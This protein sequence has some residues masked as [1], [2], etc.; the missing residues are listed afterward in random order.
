MK[1]PVSFMYN[2]ICMEM[3]HMHH[4]LYYFVHNIWFEEFVYEIMH[5]LFNKRC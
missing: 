1:I 5:T 2:I 3:I 4:V